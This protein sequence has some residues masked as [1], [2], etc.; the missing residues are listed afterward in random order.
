MLLMNAISR[1]FL[2]PG[3]LLL[4]GGALASACQS[5]P[6]PR[7]VAEAPAGLGMRSGGGANLRA[8]ETVRDFP[9]VRPDG[10]SFRLADLRGKVVVVDFWATWCPPCIKQAPQ[11]AALGARYRDRGLEVVGLTLNSRGDDAEVGRFLKQTGINYTVGYA[12]QKVSDAFLKGTE[13]NTGTAPI[14]QLFVISRDGRIVEHLI[15]EDPERGLERLEK[16]VA[17]QL[18]SGAAS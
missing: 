11:L 5:G 16:V 17:E 15:G 6:P 2:A 9:I 14:P 13:D 7:P 1:R 18:S 10:S 12:G 8:I 3:L 4:L